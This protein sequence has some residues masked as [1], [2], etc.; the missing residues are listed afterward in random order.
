M[1]SFWTAIAASLC[2]VLATMPAGAQETAKDLAARASAELRLFNALQVLERMTSQVNHFI[3]YSIEAERGGWR[4]MEKE[5][6]NDYAIRSNADRAQVEIVRAHSSIQKSKVAT[7]DE[8]K[9]AD[10]AVDN[11][12]VLIALAPQIADLITARNFDAARALAAIG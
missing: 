9:G 11:V 10:A 2:L 12:N 1:R 3:V 6:G 5:I 4:V 7:E 8:L